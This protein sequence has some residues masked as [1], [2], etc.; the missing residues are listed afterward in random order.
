MG[1]GKR[2]KKRWQ[3]AGLTFLI[4]LLLFAIGALIV[5]KVFTVEKVKVTGNEHYPDETIREWILL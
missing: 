1:K 3:S 4:I 2:K 5:L